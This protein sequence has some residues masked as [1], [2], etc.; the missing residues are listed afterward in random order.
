M[1]P[2]LQSVLARTF[3]LDGVVSAF[4]LA[5]VV[6]VAVAVA[7]ARW[8][9]ARQFLGY[10]ALSN[11]VFLLLFLLASPTT[12]LLR[13]ATYADAGEVMVPPRSTGR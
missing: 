7:E 5:A 11:V 6:G 9:P 10:L 3:G 4:A 8:R 1:R 13:G 12:D 2:I